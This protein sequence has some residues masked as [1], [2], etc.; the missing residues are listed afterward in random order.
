MDSAFRDHLDQLI[1]QLKA[2]VL[3]HYERDLATFKDKEEHKQL[4][5]SEAL[6]TKPH[7]LGLKKIVADGMDFS[8]NRVMLSR[9][10]APSDS[11]SSEEPRTGPKAP[12]H[13]HGP[14][15]P[16]IM[17]GV[18]QP[19]FMSKTAMSDSQ[20][21]SQ[22]SQGTDSLELKT[23]KPGSRVP[24]FPKP[25]QP[26]SPH[27]PPQMLEP[28]VFP[29][30]DVQSL[31]HQ[32]ENA[33]NP[34]QPEVENEEKEKKEEKREGKED[35][36]ASE[37]RS[38]ASFSSTS[39]PN[40]EMPEGPI[41]NRCRVKRP[42]NASFSEFFKRQATV[43][44][45][46]LFMQDEDSS[47]AA[48][49]YAKFMNYFVTAAIMFTV[50]QANAEPVVPRF[51]EGAIQLGVEALMLIELVAHFFSSRERRAFLKN[52][53]NIIDFCN[54]LPIAVRIP[55]GIA[56]PTRDENAVVHYV[57]Y[58]CVPVVRQLKLIRKFQKLQLL[59][60]VLATTMDALK[61]LLF[62]VCLIV[63]VFGC[64]F[65]VLEPEIMD[66]LS[67][68]IYLCT[69]TV[70]TV[71]TCDMNPVSPVGKIMAG[72]LCLT[73][74]L[75]MA[76]P[77]SVLGNAM[78]QTWADRH[79]IVLITQT[80]QKLKNLGYT[81]EHMPKLFSKFDKDGNGELEMD[82][83]C[84]LV[85]KMRI[86]MKPSEATEL[87]LAFDENG[88]GGAVQGVFASGAFGQLKFWPVDEAKGGASV[89]KVSRWPERGLC[90]TVDDLE[91]AI[92]T[93]RQLR[94][95]AAM[96]SLRL[97][98]STLSLEGFRRLLE[99]VKHL[100]QLSF[101]HCR[102]GGSP[103]LSL[104]NGQ[105]L[106]LQARCCSVDAAQL[107]DLAQ[108]FGR[109]TPKFSAMDLIA[110]PESASCAERAGLSPLGPLAWK[111]QCLDLSENHLTGNVWVSIIVEGE[112]RTN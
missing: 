102:L 3:E 5:E 12:A 107:N 89:Q 35:S 95:V 41:P 48:W 39:T 106:A 1:Q 91:E 10:T 20:E 36:S 4:P 61:L 43:T 58:C 71:G 27:T 21:S 23:P 42:S 60:H 26:F 98:A 40:D 101:L 74:V 7:I 83:F 75:F 18:A 99:E 9:R 30:S 16:R 85:A 28:R 56:T 77:L 78:S 46:Y 33:D 72:A 11:D 54:I 49:L 24:R 81:A 94:D 52:P 112:L 62:I 88:D 93:I 13:S 17:T 66:S 92:R 55:F 111:L 109:P 63:L 79:R 51:I 14:H 105:L 53:Y 38:S 15:G 59:L 65:Y 2:E 57:L 6:S 68:S 50:W 25:I 69:V 73:S 90:L 96:Q 47:K 110:K 19:R 8:R 86:G 22:A 34:Q 108:D 70:T 82:E 29:V 104:R 44:D 37:S 97:T 100:K 80:R 87:F 84:D 64:A 67:T 31:P 103:L 76:M 32:P 45:L